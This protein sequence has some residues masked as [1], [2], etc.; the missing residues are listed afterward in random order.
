MSTCALYVSNVHVGN[1]IGKCVTAIKNYFVLRKII[2]LPTPP[3]FQ[4]QISKTK[5]PINIVDQHWQTRVEQF[6]DLRY[7]KCIYTKEYL[8][9]KVIVIKG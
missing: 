7:T 8:K 9:Q 3:P 4:L 5:Y 6:L 1:F 2:C